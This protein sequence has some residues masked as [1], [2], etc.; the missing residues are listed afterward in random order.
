M[1]AEGLQVFAIGCVGAIAPEIVRIYN[2]RFKPSFRWSWGYILYSIPFVLLGGFVAWLL[3]PS[4][5]YAAFYSGV[6]TP[7]LVTTIVR[8]TGRSFPAPGSPSSSDRPSTEY[9]GDE[10]PAVAALKVPNWRSFWSAL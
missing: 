9:L 1:D 8:N 4:N 2:L 3:E 10:I 6:S 7:I 5:N